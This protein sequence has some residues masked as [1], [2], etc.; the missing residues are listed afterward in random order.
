[1][2]L[3]RLAAVPLILGALGM[4]APAGAALIVHK[5][6]SFTVAKTIAEEAIAACNAKGYSTSAVIVDPP[7]PGLHP[8]DQFRNI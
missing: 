6:L 3:V 2:S 7:R 5:D 1:M 8:K 4:S